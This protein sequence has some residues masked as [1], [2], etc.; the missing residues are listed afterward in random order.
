MEGP[1]MKVAECL[2]RTAHGTYFALLKVKGAQIKRSLE[3][4]D[5]A[6]ARCLLAELRPKVAEVDIFR[7]GKGIDIS[8]NID[9]SV[10]DSSFTT[11]L[12]STF[13]GGNEG[14]I[15]RGDCH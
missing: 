5:G 13:S 14:G 2:C 7:K 4:T 1:L 9:I 12:E 8:V 3:T 6:H 10:D 15:G 11:I